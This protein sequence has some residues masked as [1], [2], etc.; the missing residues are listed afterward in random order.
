M[1]PDISNKLKII[2]ESHIYFG[3]QSVGE[4]I[5]SGLKDIISESKQSGLRVSDLQNTI[6]DN[7]YFLH[8]K[9][10]NNGDPQSKFIEFAAKV[11]AL[12]DK[13][14][15]IAMMKLCFV[16]FNKG[17]NIESIFNSYVKMVDSLQK[18]YPSLTI[19][20]ITVP[21]KSPPTLIIKIK[22]LIKNR[23]IDDPEDNITR[24]RY[25]ELILSK[26]PQ[27]YI[28]D[29]AKAESTY[30]DDR[31]E[32]VSVNGMSSY[33]LIKEYTDDGGHLNK[34]GQR[35]IAEKLINKLFQ[36]ITIRNSNKLHLSSK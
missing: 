12:S 5:V 33:S 2:G 8:S 27:E 36:I 1:D 35:I 4:N 26:Y 14:L 16:D 19:I 13:K 3:H 34:V 10:G 28:F 15:E 21:L 20:H 17:T 32:S 30:P 31:R 6:P 9:I 25:N 29:L 23:N 11:N 24:N 22:A 18:K 7:N